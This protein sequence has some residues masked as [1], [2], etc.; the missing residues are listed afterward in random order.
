MIS[1]RFSGAIGFGRI[2]E[3]SSC[4]WQS[5]HHWNQTSAILFVINQRSPAIVTHVH[6]THETSGP[7]VA[8]RHAIDVFQHER[9]IDFVIEERPCDGVPMAN[10][11]SEDLV[12]LL[13]TGELTDL[14]YLAAEDLGTVFARHHDLRPGDQGSKESVK[15]LDVHRLPALAIFEEVPKTI[16]FRIAEGLG[17]GEHIHF[18]FQCSAIAS[19]NTNLIEGWS[20]GPKNCRSGW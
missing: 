17:F 14:R 9:N 19:Y 1:S 16:E 13:G 10:Q 3:S 20:V 4:S 15:L 7:V 8:V 18:D 12:C 6:A 2:V 11:E 5:I